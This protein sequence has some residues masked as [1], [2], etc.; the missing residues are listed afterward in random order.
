M[1]RSDHNIP[2]RQRILC[3]IQSTL[4]NFQ[5]NGLR[6]RYSLGEAV[7]EIVFV[8]FPFQIHISLSII[9]VRGI[10]YDMFTPLYRVNLYKCVFLYFNM[11]IFRFG[12][13]FTI[14][15]V[16]ERAWPIDPIHKW[17]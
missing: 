1:D 15:S 10:V 5:S 8:R 4:C 9:T 16:F 7:Y 6:R 3:L 2:T 12:L 17:N 14:R 11:E 13:W